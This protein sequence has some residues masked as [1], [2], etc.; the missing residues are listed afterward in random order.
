MSTVNAVEAI[1][2]S[3]KFGN[4]TAVDQ[5]SF[6][7]PRGEIFGLLGPNGAG[8]TTTIRMLCGLLSP[9]SGAGKVMGFDVARQPEKVKANLG[10][11]S[12]KFS[13]YNDLT[14]FENLDFY[15]R[16]YRL[17]GKTRSSRTAELL[18]MAGLKDHRTELTSNLSGAWRQRLA[19]ACA[20][21][22]EPPMLF[23]DE[24][25][26]GV[27]PVS[28]REFWN[29]IYDLAGQG[30]SVLATT[31]YMDEA[32]YCNEIGLMYQSRMI[33]RDDPDSLKE[34]LSGTLLEIE[35]DQ[36]GRAIDLLKD[37]PGVVDA[38]FHGV[39]LH[40]IVSDEALQNRLQEALE[41]NAIPVQRIER[42][43]PSLE[44]VFVGMVNAENRARLRA[45]LKQ[46]DVE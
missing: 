25:T 16:I 17:S 3:K 31:H 26:A 1:E 20:L 19:L 24:P 37:I 30:V 22:H 45:E 44:D 15:A 36:P 5:V 8:K 46:G 38:A 29:L 18:E 4:F 27:D 2:L 9:T 13:L 42:V 12:Q 33:A 40:V 39:L 32:E 14:A 10:Y 43:L 34:K 21:V 41:A 28:R 6:T 23:L 11:M 7:I 35:C